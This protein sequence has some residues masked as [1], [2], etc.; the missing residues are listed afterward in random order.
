M[1]QTEAEL[2][3]FRRK[4]REE[5]SARSQASTAAPEPV[6]SSSQVSI[7]RGPFAEPP[8]VKLHDATGD[9]DEWEPRTYGGLGDR[10]AARCLADHPSSS[11]ASTAPRS[12]LEHY[13]QA[14][15]KESQGS[16]GDSVNLYR[17]AFRV[18]VNKIR[19]LE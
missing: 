16:L 1:S 9:L 15:E 12:A 10:E 7:S 8:S 3:S 6:A 4:W 18:N 5:V 19:P 2:E 11:T 14:V 17:K 13:E